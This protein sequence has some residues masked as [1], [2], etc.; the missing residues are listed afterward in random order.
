MLRYSGPELVTQSLVINPV[1]RSLRASMQLERLL[2]YDDHRLEREV[3]EGQGTL[4]ERASLG[5]GLPDTSAAHSILRDSD[6][7]S[8]AWFRGQVLLFIRSPHIHKSIGKQHSHSVLL[9]H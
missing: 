6:G 4:A 9:L 1:C 3:T 5:G 2:Q 7:S 8:K